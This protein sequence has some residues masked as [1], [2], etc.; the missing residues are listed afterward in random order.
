MPW[1]SNCIVFA[2]SLCRRRQRK[3]REGYLLMRWSRWGPF[4]HLLYGERRRDG[5]VRLVSYK[6]TNPTK[7]KMPPP[8]FRGTSKWGDL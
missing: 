1:R 7:R 8:L 6:P 5:K 4:P 3:G 2:C